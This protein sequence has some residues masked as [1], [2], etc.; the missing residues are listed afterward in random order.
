MR[1]D[2]DSRDLYRLQGE[3]LLHGHYPR[4]EYPPG[5]VLLFALE[6]AVGNGATRGSNAF[7][8][9]P[10]QLV[11]VACI[12]ATRTR[13]SPWLAAVVA[14]WP[15]N[16]FF[17]E[18]K[19]DVV[20]TAL[21]LAGLVLAQR[22][23]WSLA[24]VVFGIGTLVK[25]TPALALL[26][27]GAW[28]VTTGRLAVARRFVISFVATVGA[29]YLP[30]IAWAPNAVLAAYTRQ[31]GRTITPESL[32]YLLLHAVGLASKRTFVTL[33]ANV[34][35]WAGA[36]TVT[37]QAALVLGVVVVAARAPSL[38]RAIAIA[39]VAPVTF[40]ITNRIFSAQ[41]IVLLMAAWAIAGALVVR[42][43]RS[44]LIVGAAACAASFWNAFVYPYALPHYA[45]MWQVSSALF[46]LVAIALTVWLV[47]R[48]LDYR[49]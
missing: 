32:W 48:S 45:V 9:I 8:M 36:A 30:L 7:L 19:F 2:T 40:L 38:N 33:A 12:W 17:W 31:G 26:A 41:F 25:W 44:Q 24:G 10:F 42:D 37:I 35:G 18:F 21:L 16:A 6:A 22:E 46:F 3:S 1:G 43:Q 14:V 27:L 28:L 49:S 23:G 20:P 15:L 13:Y 39:A 47:A 4:S 5:A 11:S 34:P 29:V